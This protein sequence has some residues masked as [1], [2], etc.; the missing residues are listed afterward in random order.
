MTGIADT[1]FALATAR[2]RAG[3]AIV[4]ISGPGAFEAAEVMTG[5]LP[6][7]GRRLRSLTARGGEVVDQALVLT[8]AAG[9][10][11]TGENVVEFQC[12]GGIAIIDRILRELSEMDGLRLAQAGE[13]TRRALGNGRLDLAEVEGLASLVEAET[14]G[15]R[16]QAMRLFS[17]ELGTL[18]QN[19]RQSLLEP[20][21]LIEA[22]MD[23][24]DEDVPVDVVPG[25]RSSII[26]LL[27]ELKFHADGAHVAERMMDGFEVAIIGA[28]NLGKS[29]LLNRIAGRDAA[30]TSHHAGTT[31][32]VIE[33][34]MDLNGL[35][36]TMLDTAG[37][38]EAMDDVERLGIERGKSRATLAD[39]RVHLCEAPGD[40]DVSEGDDDIV[41]LAKDDDGSFGT[42]SISGVTGHGVD[43]LIEDIAQRLAQRA[44]NAGVASRERHRRALVD[45]ML[46]LNCALQRLD[47]H[48]I[49]LDIVAEDLRSAGRS[50]DVLIGRIDVEDVLGVIFERFCIG[51]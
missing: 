30:I 24:V 10:S 3:V 13:F 29:T 46:H 49:R 8:F 21:A 22:T 39:L 18:V 51:K 17:G 6:R 42:K 4:R 43:R 37:L 44:G 12:H 2:G 34:R 41:L 11:F 27:A 7:N 9:K 15:Q 48:D 31:R 28:P 23:F 40:T 35:P 25:V 33:V 14:E 47:A 20:V 45:A 1:I 38:R 5:P 16:K 36:V 50:L 26:K 19:W 32:D